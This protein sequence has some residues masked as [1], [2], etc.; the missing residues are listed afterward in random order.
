MCVHMFVTPSQCNYRTNLDEISMQ[1]DY[2]ME[3]ELTLL[4][5]VKNPWHIICKE[6]VNNTYKEYVN[7]DS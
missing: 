7:E 3:S 2:T 1:V 5:S 6:Y 4:L